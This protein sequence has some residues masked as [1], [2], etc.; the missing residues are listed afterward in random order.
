MRR[1]S[2]ETQLSVWTTPV[3]RLRRIHRRDRLGRV[4][5]AQLL[6]VLL[7]VAGFGT[8]CAAPQNQPGAADELLVGFVSGTTSAE[9]TA[10]Y[11][12]L[13]AKKIEELRNIGVHRIQ[14]APGSLEST[15]RALQSNP[16]VRFVER[17]RQ[18]RSN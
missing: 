10:I 3:G 5:S 11:E 9:A 15:E 7:V 6:A 2:P 17:N 8:S 4:V 14:V 18:L 1:T 12:P 16:A 13:G